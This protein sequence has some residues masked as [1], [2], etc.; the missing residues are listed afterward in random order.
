VAYGRDGQ[1]TGALYGSVDGKSWSLYRNITESYPGLINQVLE[2]QAG[3]STIVALVGF[4][5]YT[6]RCLPVFAL[7]SHFSLLSLFRFSVFAIA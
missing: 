3:S 4:S 2:L 7:S 5:D 6:V 1:S